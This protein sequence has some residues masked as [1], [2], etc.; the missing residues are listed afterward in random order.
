MPA[1]AILCAAAVIVAVR[2]G[3][4]EARAGRRPRPLTRTAA[5]KETGRDRA[6][7][8]CSSPA[9]QSYLKMMITRRFF[10]LAPGFTSG[11]SEP[12]ASTEMR[13]SSTPSETSW[14]LTALARTSLSDWL[15]AWLPL[16][17]AWPSITMLL[18][19][20]ALSQC[21]VAFSLPFDCLVRL[22]DAS[23]K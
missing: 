6:I 9:P 15:A 7:P 18:S 21:L 22:D 16:V 17:L 10:G 23:P 1:L 20:L 3:L 11:R 8:P 13:D 4:R 5:G 12:N 14:S 2:I 19:G